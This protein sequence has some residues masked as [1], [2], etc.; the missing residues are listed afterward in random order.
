MGVWVDLW[1]KDQAN[2]T[3]VLENEWGRG[4]M[5]MDAAIQAKICHGERKGI[6]VRI[7]LIPVDR[8]K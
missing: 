4:L 1:N 3:T 6:F 7:Q 8:H 2:V 5:S